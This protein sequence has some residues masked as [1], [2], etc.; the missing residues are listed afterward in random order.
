[1]FVYVERGDSRHRSNTSASCSPVAS[2]GGQ[3]N[4]SAVYRNT[5]AYCPIVAMLRFQRRH[6]RR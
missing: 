2:S 1:M 6:Q 3:P 5:L 4:R